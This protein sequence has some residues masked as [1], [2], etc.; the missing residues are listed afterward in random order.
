MKTG[1]E[2]ILNLFNRAQTTSM[3]IGELIVSANQL[4]DI[5]LAKEAQQLYKIWI[6]FHIDD[7]YVHMAYFNYAVL[8]SD[9]KDYFEAL[10]A[11]KEA[12]KVKP[13]FYPAYINIG[14]VYEALGHMSEAQMSWKYIIDNTP[15]ITKENISYKLGAFKQIARL[16]TSVDLAE[17]EV[18]LSNSLLINPDQPEIIQ[19]YLSLR[20]RQIKWPVIQESS[21]VTKKKQLTEIA[22]LTLACYVDDPVYQLA[23]AAYYNKHYLGWP[24]FYYN[25]KDYRFKKESRNK[26]IKIGYVSSD[27]R[28]HAVGYAMAEVFEL[29]NRHNVEVYAYYCGSVRFPDA[30]QNRLK[31]SADHWTDIYG[32]DDKTVA[33]KII[34]DGIQII[35]DLNGYTKD[36]RTVLFGMRPAPIIVNW[37]GYPS[38]M[39]SPYHNYIIADEVI[40]PKSHEKYYSEKVARL[41]CYQPND[42]KKSISEKIPLRSDFRLPEEAFVYCSMNGFQK[43]NLSTFKLWLSIISQVPNSVLW[44][45]SDLNSSHEILRGIAKSYGISA[46]RLIFTGPLPNPDHL[47]RYRLADLFLDSMPYGAHTTAADCLWMGTP[48]ITLPGQSFASRVCASL[49]TASDLKELIAINAEDYVEKAVSLALNKKKY[50]LIKK[51]LVSKR[52]KCLLFNSPQLVKDLEDLYA[53]MWNDFIN[54]SLPKPNLLNIDI[55]HDISVQLEHE[56]I[57]L[58]NRSDNDT[59][60]YNLMQK[61]ND[62]LQIPRDGRL[63][64]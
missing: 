24:E 62:Y 21:F 54:G 42:R 25:D 28:A 20:Q 49:L 60:Y 18:A 4:K 11:L 63:W 6:A 5:G 37:F 40:I 9:N 31:N 34:E 35:I 14:N 56:N 52:D 30:T 41:K 59:I 17:A 38:T 48:I 23:N 29:H 53:S 33:N 22:P 64:I 43:L 10:R 57:G 12:A 3:S 1:Q 8:Q 32:V 44:L 16:A 58:I 50:S 15:N 27:L 45:L 13:E 51:Q 26:P 7:D 61:L 55:Y 46:E 39:G 2:I 47:A 36:A 19:Q